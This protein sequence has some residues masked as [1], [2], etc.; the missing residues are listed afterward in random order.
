MVETFFTT[1]TVGHC[2][3]LACGAVQTRTDL[4]LVVA[5]ALKGW[6][7]DILKH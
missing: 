5:K 1:I 6:D 2:Y 4:A 7:G 3:T